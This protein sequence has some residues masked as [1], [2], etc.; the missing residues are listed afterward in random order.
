ML[1]ET[2]LDGSGTVTTFIVDP[3]S[4]PGE[5]QVT[6]STERPVRSSL[7]GNIERVL[8]THLLFPIYKRELELLAVRAQQAVS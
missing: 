2:S 1:V 6:I 7:F 4:A 5:S 8:S 3:G